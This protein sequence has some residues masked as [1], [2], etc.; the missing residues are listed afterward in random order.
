MPSRTLVAAFA[1]T[2]TL[3]SPMRAMTAPCDCW[4]SFPVSNER[5]LS[6]PLIGPD[7]EMASAMTLLVC[8]R[9]R[10]ATVGPVPS[11]RAPQLVPGPSARRLAAGLPSSLRVL[12]SAQTEAGDELPIPLDV[13]PLD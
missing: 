4:A 5:D 8:L 6:V 13:I 11:W 9:H 10:G 2:N 1:V 12:L 3:V 7:T